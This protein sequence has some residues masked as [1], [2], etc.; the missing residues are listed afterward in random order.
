MNESDKPLPKKRKRG[1]PPNNKRALGNRGGGRKTK[2]IAAFA[3]IARKATEQ[4]MTDCQVANLLN[5]SESTLYRWRLERPQFARAFR[6]GKEEADRRVERA[7][8]QRAVGFSFQAEKVFI[9]PDGPRLVRCREHLPPDRTAAPFYLRNRCP[10]RWG[11]TQ[12]MEHGVTP[13]HK[14]GDTKELAALLQKQAQQLGLIQRPIE[15]AL[16][17]PAQKATAGPT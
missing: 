12:R 17:E 11:D 10:E 16:P 1:A 8:Y 3:G 13:H 6:L 9:T 2:Y 4:G 7:L 5:I 15:G 14:I